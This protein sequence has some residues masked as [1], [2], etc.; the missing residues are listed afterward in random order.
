MIAPGGE[1]ATARVKPW[2]VRTRRARNA[3]DMLTLLTC[4]VVVVVLVPANLVVAPLG[5]FGTPA[6]ILGLACFG[7]WACGRIHPGLGLAR[8]FQP[9]RFAVLALAVCILLSY[10]VATRRAITTLELNAADRGLLFLA[11]WSGICLIAADALHTRE[12]VETLLKRLVLA[13]SF[14]AIVGYLQFFLGLDLTHYL[15]VPGLRVGDTT[16]F[17]EE[18]SG[19][20][21]VAGTATHPIE[22]GVVLAATLPIAVHFGLHDVRERFVRRWS[23]VVIISGAILLSISRSAIICVAVAFLVIFPQWS[24]RLRLRAF[25]AL[26]IFLA[27]ARAAVPG[28]VGTI[29]N[30]FLLF[31]Q[32]SS[33]IHRAEASAAVWPLVR[34]HLFFGIG[35]HTYLPVVYH[36]VL[37][38]AYLCNLVETGIV[39]TVLL[40]LTLIIAISTARAARRNF[41]APDARHLSI[42]LAGSLT[43]L[44]VS[45][46]TYDSLSFVMFDIVFFLLIGVSGA[47]YR[48]SRTS[49]DA[50]SGRVL[51][52]IPQDRSPEAKSA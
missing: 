50:S 43:A 27:V 41:L 10:I 24:W 40:A 2:V 1:S 22:F 32:D 49:S 29:S 45:F 17:V 34:S 33:T 28:L 39:G 7:C 6:N 47:L 23:P 8:G 16:G 13:V 12:E 46:A 37:D 25:L 48:I 14:L 52:E 26:P 51:F 3:P 38:N 9:I 19:F 5:A 44:A 35:F 20:R 15:H 31:G 30:M 21:R 4:V 18:R 11:S 36:H 42:A